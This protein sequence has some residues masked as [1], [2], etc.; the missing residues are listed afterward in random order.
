[1]I[2]KFLITILFTLVLCGGA[3]AIEKLPG[4]TWA[5][6]PSK[7]D[8]LS[9]PFQIQFYDYGKCKHIKESIRCYYYLGHKNKL[10]LIL[11]EY[12]ISVGIIN[13]GNKISGDGSNIE[14][15]KWKFTAIKIGS[16]YQGFN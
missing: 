2:K 1:M 9:Q 15:K 4:T 5:F 11:N 10:H 6:T 12:S 7:I 16:D 14:G 13:N 3:S 8:K